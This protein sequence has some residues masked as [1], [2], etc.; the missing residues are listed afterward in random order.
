MH[1]EWCSEFVEKGNSRTIPK[2][3]RNELSTK[4]LYG[5][6]FVFDNNADNKKNNYFFYDN[7]NILS[8]YIRMKHK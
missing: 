2:E 6:F 8:I 5:I 1:K 4:Q 7:Y 3:E